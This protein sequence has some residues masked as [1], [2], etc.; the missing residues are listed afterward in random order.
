M[1]ITKN[2]HLP[3]IRCRRSKLGAMVGCIP[4]TIMKDLLYIVENS[5]G[6]L[7]G[8]IQTIFNSGLDFFMFENIL[9]LPQWNGLIIWHPLLTVCV[10]DVTEI[11]MLKCL[12]M[13]WEAVS[14]FAILSQ[15][16][17]FARVAKWKEIVENGVLDNCWGFT[18][19]YSIYPHWEK[20]AM[21]R[22]VLL[23]L[24]CWW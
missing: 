18:V 15:Q 24:K 16:V 22:R 23:K 2:P 17:F 13:T 3:T 4:L 19:K 7:L 6:S 10:C 9:I 8:Y 14:T 1:T 21:S 11:L 12:G 20:K 5:I